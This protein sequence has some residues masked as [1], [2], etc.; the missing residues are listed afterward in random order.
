M[1]YESQWVANILCPSP[2]EMYS[3]SS[4]SYIACAIRQ[5]LFCTSDDYAGLTEEYT[6]NAVTMSAF[7]PSFVTVPVTSI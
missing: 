4:R 5:R 7:L 2:V 1:L 6:S 3:P